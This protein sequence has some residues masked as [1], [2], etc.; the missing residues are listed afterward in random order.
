[1]RHLR[2]FYMNLHPVRACHWAPT[3]ILHLHLQKREDYVKYNKLADQSKALVHLAR[4]PYVHPC[5]HTVHTAFVT[6]KP[7]QLS[8]LPRTI[9]YTS[10]P[11]PTPTPLLHIHLQKREDYVKYNKLAGMCK[12]LTS[13]LAQL[14]PTDTC[15]VEVTE[16]FLHKLY[17]MGLVPTEKRCVWYV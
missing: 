1:M 6:L 13:K 4:I 7:P 14:A 12:A 15:R 11:T 16:K 9:T 8:I 3:P 10:T 5:L 2:H 17:N